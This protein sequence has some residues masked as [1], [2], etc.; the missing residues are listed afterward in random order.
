MIKISRD[1]SS[2]NFTAFSVIFVLISDF[3]MTLKTGPDPFFWILVPAFLA[4]LKN[5]F[6]EK[7]KTSP[8]HV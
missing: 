6:K 1:P 2:L 7:Y 3:L 4:V 5:D 8:M